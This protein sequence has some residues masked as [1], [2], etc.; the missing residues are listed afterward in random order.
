MFIERIE[1][2]STRA[3]IRTIF[4]TFAV[5]LFLLFLH[6]GLQESVVRLRVKIMN[7]AS[8]IQFIDEGKECLALDAILIKVI[9]FPIRSCHL[10]DGMHC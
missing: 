6:G 4:I 10:M 3:C 1:I 9:W 5:Y 2:C 7:N 8:L